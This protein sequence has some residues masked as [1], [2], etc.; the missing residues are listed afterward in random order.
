[1]SLLKRI[2]REQIASGKLYGK[3][4]DTYYGQNITLNSPTLQWTTQ[5]LTLMLVQIFLTFEL[6][7]IEVCFDQTLGR[8][9]NGLT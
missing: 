4:I 7:P 5:F 6:E 9:F 3:G 8:K 2:T 1:M